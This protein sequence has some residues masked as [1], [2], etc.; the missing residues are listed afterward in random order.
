[1]AQARLSHQTSSKLLKKM[2]FL[3]RKTPSKKML[4]A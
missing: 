1:M 4:S 3:T 2:V